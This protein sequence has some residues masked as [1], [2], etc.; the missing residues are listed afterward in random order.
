[1]VSRYLQPF[2]V[3]QGEER[4]R[5]GLAKAR[6]LEGAWRLLTWKRALDFEVQGSFGYQRVARKLQQIAREL[7]G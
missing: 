7:I 3:F 6:G 5:E 1:M 4:L 2:T